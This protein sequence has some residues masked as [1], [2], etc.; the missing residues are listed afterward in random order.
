MRYV[1][2]AWA[3]AR[4]AETDNRRP[5]FTAAGLT[6]FLD[7]Q[8]F[9]SETMS[10]DGEMFAQVWPITN[11]QRCRLSAR[12]SAQPRPSIK[13]EVLCTPCRNMV[14]AF[15]TNQPHGALT[16]YIVDGLVQDDLE[17][18]GCRVCST[19]LVRDKKSRDFG[20][21]WRLI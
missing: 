13:P 6:N 18:Y 8:L 5:G 20:V 2:T 7:G 17:H 14:G 12:K 19:K 4:H 21:R 16:S 15:V 9:G 10:V 11:A 3:H 1:R